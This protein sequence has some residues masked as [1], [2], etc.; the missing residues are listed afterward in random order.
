VI[1]G[2]GL[3]A[4]AWRQPGG[5]KVFEIHHPA[6]LA[7]KRQ[8]LRTLGARE[9]DGLVWEP[10]HVEA[11]PVGEVLK[12]AGL[13][14]AQTFVNWVGVSSYLS[15]PAIE[16]TLRSL[17]P[18]LVAI[19]HTAPVGQSGPSPGVSLALKELAGE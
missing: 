9:P 10:A 3:D 1:L 19:T 2:A 11:E 12:R 18:G 13:T 4:F 6:M 16:A 8:R 15:K 14:S 17:P 7:F 5:V